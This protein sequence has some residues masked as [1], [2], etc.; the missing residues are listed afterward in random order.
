MTTMEEVRTLRRERAALSAQVEELKYQIE[1]LT[2]RAPAGWEP[3][4][5][6]I[7]ISPSERAVL[8]VLLNQR[9]R[10]L[11][12][13]QIMLAL[14]MNGSRAEDAKIVD[15]YICRL[16]RAF[17]ACRAPVEIRTIWGQ[18]FAAEVRT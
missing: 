13:D 6:G 1:C 18:G 5:A 14:E 7:R 16:R 9:G 10:V 15:I 2:G 8:A 17:R 4:V 3:L 12:R 11:S